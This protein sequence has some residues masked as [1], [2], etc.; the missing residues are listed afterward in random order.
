MASRKRKSISYKPQVQFDTRRFQSLEAWNRYTDNILDQRIF[1]ERNV[2]IYHT[3]FDEFKVELERR[4]LHKRLANLQEGSIDVAMVKEFYA[5]LYNSEDQVP[6]LRYDPRE[7]EV[8]LC[9]PGKGFVL[10]IEGQPWKLLIKDLTTLA[11]T[12]SVFSYSNLAPTSHTSNL[13]IDRAR[14]RGV[15]SDALT[16]YKSLRLVII[17]AYI[18]RKCWNV[19]DQIVNF[20]RAR[21]T[22]S[23]AAGVPS[24]PVSTTPSAQSSQTS[25]AK[26]QSLFEGQILI[27][28]SLQELAHQRPI[29]SVEQFIEQVA[30]PRAQP[31]FVSDYG[32]YTAQ[33]PQQQKPEPKDHQSSEATV[34]RA[35]DVAEGRS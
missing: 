28:Q 9:I 2:R 8:I 16:A 23:R 27:M 15:G 11:Q 3:E 20:P 22:R 34:P 18:K 30:W 10:N 5:N 32:S 6:K 21:K 24:S 14:S 31:S 35:F 13:N 1:L 33:A 29:M 7:M 26:L 12:W 19:N 17:L 4:N 25:D